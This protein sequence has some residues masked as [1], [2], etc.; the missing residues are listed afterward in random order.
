MET[1]HEN[2]ALACDDAY[3]SLLLSDYSQDLGDDQT[4][5]MLMSD[6]NYAE[7]LQVQEG[8][9]ASLM[10]LHTNYQH[11]PGNAFSPFSVEI[12][13]SSKRRKISMETR[14]QC[15]ICAE[16]KNNQEFFPIQKC[17]HRF[18][19]KCISKHISI[20][21]KKGTI[22]NHGENLPCPGTDCKGVL[23]IDKCRK[24]VPRDVLSKWDDMMIESMILPSQKFYCPY[25]SC[26]GLL[27][28]DSYNN[29]KDVVKIKEAE[30]P[31]CNRLFCAKCKVPW[32]PGIGCDG[33]SRLSQNEREREDLMVDKLA[34]KN[35]WQRCPS[36]RFFVEK[37]GGCLHM[38][39]RSE[40]Y[41]V[42]TT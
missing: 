9:M 16:R 37:K 17:S 1:Q 4:L 18:C 25:K 38:T 20:K 13:E 32:H 31:Y 40:L 2:I 14:Y 30:C 35:K 7:K 28:N 11:L 33:F 12:G 27:V 41:I 39:C 34:K 5:T 8:I 3:I 10:T 36:C 21:I 24:I 15:E 6:E 26:S 29:N 22:A 42:G 23:E 19:R